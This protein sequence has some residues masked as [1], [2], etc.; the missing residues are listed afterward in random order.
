[1]L[2]SALS[3]YDVLIP[4]L[5]DLQ[6]TH[7]ITQAQCE[8]CAVSLADVEVAVS[9]LTGLQPQ[10]LSLAPTCLDDLW[11]DIQQVG[12]SLSVDPQPLLALLQRRV[13]HV[14]AQMQGRSRPRV[15]CIEWSDPLMAAGN[16]VPEL[17]ALAGGESCFGVVGQHSPWLRWD[18]FQA[19]DPDVLILMPCGYDLE[20]TATDATSLAT[21]PRWSALRAVQ[22]QQVYL[23]DGN[24]YFNR[25]GPRLVDSLEILAEILHPG[26]GSSHYRGWGWQR[27]IEHDLV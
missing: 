12:Q 3:V 8:V 5:E 16:W 20:R 13:Q 11:S 2:R 27:W 19:A 14:Q 15:G 17:V 4:V 24:A 25:P 23:T 1:L 22:Q 9:Q 6:P 18:E 10:V 7:I 21:D 26:S